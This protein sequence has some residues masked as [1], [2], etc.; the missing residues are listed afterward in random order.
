[1]EA[2]RVAIIAD[3]PAADARNRPSATTTMTAAVLIVFVLVYLGMILGGLPFLQLDRTGIAFLGAIAIVGIGA[4][5]P[6][7]AA[8]TIHLPTMLLLPLATHPLSGPLL[9]LVS[10]LAG[11]LIIV[12]SIAN[13]IVVDVAARRGIKIDWRTHAR[14]GIG[15]TAASL[16]IAAAW[17]AAYAGSV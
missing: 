7:Q 11:N 16:S 9:A 15:V 6:E 14:V 3:A 1:M 10:T 17:L 4:L 5:T 2:C 8:L 12:G 13:I